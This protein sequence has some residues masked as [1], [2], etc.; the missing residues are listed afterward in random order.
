MKPRRQQ[1]EEGPH[2]LRDQTAVVPSPRMRHRTPQALPR[3]HTIDQ[4]AEALAVSSRTVRRW[5]AT[6]ALTGHRFNGV[7]R[8]AERDFLAFLAV[9]RE[10]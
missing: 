4:V 6:G 5:I 8:I 3:F 2:P 1:L 7:V 9:H 10:G